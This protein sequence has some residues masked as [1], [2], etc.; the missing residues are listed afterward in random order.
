MAKSEP[1]NEHGVKIG[2]VERS[3]KEIKTLQ[4]KSESWRK[5]HK[6]KQA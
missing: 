2:E 6:M 1:W 5:R 4:L 3:E